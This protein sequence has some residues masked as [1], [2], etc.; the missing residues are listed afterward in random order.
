MQVWFEYL[1]HAVAEPL[2][3]SFRA[4]A[5]YGLAVPALGEGGTIAWLLLGS[6]ARTRTAVA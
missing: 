3:P 5:A 2:V 6:P 4:V 1:L